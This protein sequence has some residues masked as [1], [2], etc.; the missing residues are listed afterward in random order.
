MDCTNCTEKSVCQELCD[1]MENQLPGEN[2]GDIM[3]YDNANHVVVR[4]DS[5]EELDFIIQSNG[6]A[7]PQST[8]CDE[9]DISALES[10]R[11]TP[12]QKRMAY[13]KYFQ[14]LGNMNIAMKMRLDPGSVLST[15]R[16]IERK[17]ITGMKKKAIWKLIKKANWPLDQ[18]HLEMLQIAEMYYDKLMTQTEIADELD[19]CQRKISRI[20]KKI[21][22]ILPKSV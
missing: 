13:F 4:Y 6:L 3:D 10:F 8:L 12:V 2:D 18:K 15:L 16:S 9:S 1:T 22:D 21:A 20:L 5:E 17:V 19:V 7:E 14:G 11:L